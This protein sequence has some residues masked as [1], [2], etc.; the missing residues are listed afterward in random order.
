VSFICAG[1]DPQKVAHDVNHT[2]LWVTTRFSSMW[3]MDQ[4]LSSHHYFSLEGFAHSALFEGTTFVW[5]ALMRLESYLKKQPVKKFKIPSGVYLV[6][7]ELISIGPG[8]TIE[9]GAFIQGPV[10]IGPN[11]TIR[12]GAY[13]RGGVITGEGCLIGHA[14]EV[15]HSIFLNGA[16]AAHFNYVGDSILGNEVN[17]GAGVK[18]ANYRLDHREVVVHVHNKKISTGL[19]K[20]GAVVGDGVQIGCNS[21][22]SP[23][24]LIGPKTLCLPCLNIRGV[25]SAKSLYKESV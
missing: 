6:N 25:I 22:T 17:L 16:K 8:T 24:T 4:K 2:D 10:L 23:G 3:Q 12:H 5:E 7:P 18:L 21:V 20:F 11:N 15:K 1:G 14:T 13:I 9:P 19:K